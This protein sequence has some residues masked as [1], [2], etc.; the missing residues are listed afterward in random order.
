MPSRVPQSLPRM[1][2][3]ALHMAFDPSLRQ[4]TGAGRLAI[5]LDGSL[6]KHGRDLNVGC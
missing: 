4:V 5:N 6:A 1:L 2:I 3:C